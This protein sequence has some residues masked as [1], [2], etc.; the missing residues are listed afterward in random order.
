M[1]LPQRLRLLLLIVGLA[2][3]SAGN[4]QSAITLS[5]DIAPQ[6]V[7]E[8]L[9]AFSRQTGVQIIY[10]SAI[11]EAQHSNGVRAGLSVVEALGQLL[12]GTGLRYEF[13]NARTIRVFP[14]SPLAPDDGAATTASQRGVDQHHRLGA[15]ALD[16]VVVTATRREEHASRVPISITVWTDDAMQMSGVKSMAEI[17][18]MTPGIDFAIRSNVG[19]DVYTDLFIRGV[20]NRYGPVVGIFMDD[21]PIPPSRCATFLRS[22]PPSFDLER[23]EVLLGPQAT[24]LGDHTQGGAIRFIMNQPSLTDDSGIVRAEWSTL[25][26]GDLSYEA[27]AA[28]GGPIIADVLGYRISG[29]YRSDGG[30]I[31][32]VDPTTGATIDGDANHYATESVRG[33]I[34]LA[35]SESVRITPSLIY[36][37]VRVHD[38]STFQLD[39]SDLGR[40][41]FRNAAPITQPFADAFYM[42]SLKL[43]ARIRGS[44]LSSVTSYFSRDAAATF[45]GSIATGVGPSVD[46]SPWNAGLEQHVIAS[47]TRLASLETGTRLSWVAG[48][49]LLRERDRHW[50]SGGAAGTDALNVEQRQVAAFGQVSVRLT[51]RLSADAG[52]RVGRSTYDSET[53]LRPVF[54][55]VDANNWSAPRFALSYQRDERSLFYLTTAKGYGSGGVYPG[56]LPVSP[57]AYPADTLWSYEAG[58]KTSLLDNRLRLDSSVFHIHW[59][60]GPPNENQNIGE[61]DPVPGPANSNGFSVAAHAFIGDRISAALGIAYT[62][63]RY[64]ETEMSGSDVWVRKGDA[65]GGSPWTL[66]GSIERDVALRGGVVARVRA[67]DIFHSQQLSPL[68]SD[69]QH[70]PWYN[71]AARDSSTNM[72]NIRVDFQWTGFDVAA[73]VGNALNARPI[74]HGSAV[75]I[76]SNFAAETLPPRALGLSATWRL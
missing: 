22:F 6:S 50:G 64:A 51:T 20:S 44:D 76:Y 48:L 56:I 43:T 9:D 70:A 4:A 60:N 29:W 3:P 66:S 37:S 71:P 67:E 61:I 12:D 25:E 18:S 8:A 74:L 35:P 46:G 7:A 39:V 41:E 5:V 40:G 73:F 1:T 28:V 19:G 47:E 42:G 65:V 68:Y 75:G 26:S 16:E 24:L 27:G 34:T 21:T 45:D 57:S 13:L 62:N 23:V 52:L 10:V 54:H 17:G 55:A 49:F 59:D 69:N 2:A 11:V 63:A 31:D 72:L 15:A 30:Y 53:E 36:Q 38:M 14:V 33:A 32:R 58:A